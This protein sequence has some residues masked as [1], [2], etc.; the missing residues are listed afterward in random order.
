MQA[1]GDEWAVIRRWRGQDRKS[2][3]LSISE[4][5]II[6]ALDLES[7]S[8]SLEIGENVLGADLG[9]LWL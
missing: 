3:R 9:V 2:A 5:L 6:F 4:L 7:V 1:Q 8:T